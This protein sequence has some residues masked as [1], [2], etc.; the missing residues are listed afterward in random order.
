MLYVIEPLVLHRLEQTVADDAS[1]ARFDRMEW[2]HR[3][4]LAL[5]LITVLAAVGGAHG[6]F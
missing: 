4:M 3:I 1:D 5:S 6:L 2:F